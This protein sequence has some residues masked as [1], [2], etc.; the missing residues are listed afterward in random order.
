MEFLTAIP[1]W[2]AALIIFSLRIVDVSFSTLRTIA[3]VQGRIKL[4][5]FLGFFETF[6]W[7]TAAGQALV[8][9]QDSWLMPVAYSAGFAAGSAV[10]IQIDR[11][12]A[13][14]LVVVRM[15]SAQMGGEIAGALRRQGWKPTLFQ[16]HGAD[17]PNTL[18]Y[19]ICPRRDASR[20]LES[21]QEIDPHVYYSVD[22]VREYYGGAG[23][24]L[25]SPAG[26]R[27]IL[28]KK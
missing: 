20:L 13:M 18:I 23:E 4:S 10:G 19:V 14:G 21:A 12:I 8:A 7:L 6:V 9:F 26:W 16:G 25:A 27:A 2:T 5:I 11:A 1:S 3:V 15:F 28:R 24:A 22:L 17:G